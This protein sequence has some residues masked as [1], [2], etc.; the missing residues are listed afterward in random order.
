MKIMHYSE[1][2][3]KH[4]DSDSVKGMTGRVVIGKADGADNYCMRFFELS[5]NGHSPAHSHEWEHEIIIHSGQGEVLCKGEWK[6]VKAGYVIF[7]P[8][9]EEHQLRNTGSEKMVFACIIP[10]GPPEL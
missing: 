4:I 1:A 7:I 5:E 2:E 9:N 10:S 3:S 8:G 6:P